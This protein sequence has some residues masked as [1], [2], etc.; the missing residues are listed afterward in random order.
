[1][2]IYPYIAE[3]VEGERQR[4]TIQAPTRDRAVQELRKSGY[5]PVRVDVPDAACDHH[6]PDVQT[7]PD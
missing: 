2:P 3:D 1:M 4:G 6:I 7:D 5:R